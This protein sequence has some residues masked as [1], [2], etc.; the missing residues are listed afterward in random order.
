MV[1]KAEV[2]TGRFSFLKLGSCECVLRMKEDH[3]E[4]VIL[5]YVEHV[6]LLCADTEEISRVK[7][8]LQT[9]FKLKHLGE[10]RHYPRVT[11]DRQGTKL[12]LPQETYCSRVLESFR[13]DHAK[14]VPIPMAE[15]IDNLSMPVP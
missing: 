10:L 15:K 1:R 2:H 3:R 12:L 13:M 11:F 14:Y 4:V 6:V 5:V 8:R 9:L 7:R